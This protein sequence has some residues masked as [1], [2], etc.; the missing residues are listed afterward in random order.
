MRESG[1]QARALRFAQ[2]C[3]EGVADGVVALEG[4]RVRARGGRGMRSG[5]TVALCSPWAW[6]TREILGGI[7]LVGRGVDLFPV[8]LLWGRGWR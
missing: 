5:L 4:K 6:R 2:G 8:L 1:F 7:G 3:E